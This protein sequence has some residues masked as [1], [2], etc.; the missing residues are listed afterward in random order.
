MN[1]SAALKDGVTHKETKASLSIV[2][3]SDIGQK[4]EQIIPNAKKLF[5]DNNVSLVHT[6]SEQEWPDKSNN[7]R[8]RAKPYTPGSSLH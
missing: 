1:S 2:R 7:P 4:A 8:G 5:E 6:V 3:D